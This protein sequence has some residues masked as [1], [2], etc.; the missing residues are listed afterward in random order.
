MS[1]H[2]PRAPDAL[3]EVFEAFRQMTVPDRPGDAE[4]LARLEDRYHDKTRLVSPDGRRTEGSRHLARVL[5]PSAAAAV[6][7]LA[8]LGLLFFGGAVPI[9]MADVL[10][11]AAKHSLVRYQQQQIIDTPEHVGARL[12]S[13]VY[14][15]LKTAR[16]RTE[17]RTAYPDGEAVLVSIQDS[18]RQLMIDSR[19][20]TARLGRTPKDFKSFCCSLEEFEQNE[21]VTQVSEKLGDLPT[22]KYSFQ[23]DNQTTSL[24]VD[25]KTRLPVRMEQALVEP[26]PDLTRT[27]FIWTDFEWDPDLPAGIRNVD[28]LFS[29]SPPKDYA[30]DDDLEAAKPTR[31]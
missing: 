17:S 2:H 10:R 7:L 18:E 12:E 4:V 25:A 31:E 28:E 13:T 1:E 5:L 29:T 9:A 30:L 3:D 27:W 24:W 15:D 23:K 22:V 8:G 6:L 11:T 26:T 14:S 20:K 21:G 16:R 19:R